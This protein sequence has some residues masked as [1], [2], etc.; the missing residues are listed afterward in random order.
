[1]RIFRVRGESSRLGCTTRKA[2][3]G[4][5][6]KSRLRK[7]K[8]PRSTRD[9]NILALYKC[10]T[11][12]NT[13]GNYGRHMKKQTPPS[14]DWFALAPQ[15][16]RQFVVHSC[17][18]SCLLNGQVWLTCRDSSSRSFTSSLSCCNPFR[19]A[20]DLKQQPW[21]K[22]AQQAILNLFTQYFAHSSIQNHVVETLGRA[23]WASERS[24]TCGA[25]CAAFVPPPH[26]LR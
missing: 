11:S 22:A 7:H 3:R 15:R 26:L 5:K 10:S 24:R 2:E 25:F 14:K 8:Q 19:T 23:D 18:S 17:R 13:I 21:Q 20:D 16:E 1:M 6:P 9:K 4:E 12:K